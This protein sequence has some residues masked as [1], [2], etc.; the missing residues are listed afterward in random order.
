MTSCIFNFYNSEVYAGT[1]F[2][3]MHRNGEKEVSP[4]KRLRD[5]GAFWHRCMA[6][7]EYPGIL[8]GLRVQNYY[9]H[10]DCFSI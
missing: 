6:Y 9:G 3:G 4:K 1:E 10:E 7:S 5:N 2:G 8:I